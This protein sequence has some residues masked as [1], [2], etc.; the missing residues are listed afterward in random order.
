MGQLSDFTPEIQDKINLVAA[1][2]GTT[3]QYLIDNHYD[4]CTSL[5]S[6]T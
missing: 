3:T 5:E 2:W 6:N 4:F 1:S